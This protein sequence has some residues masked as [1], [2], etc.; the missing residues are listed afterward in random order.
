LYLYILIKLFHTSAYTDPSFTMEFSA[1]M[2]VTGDV[3]VQ[4]KSAFE[5]EANKAVNLEKISN[6]LSGRCGDLTG[7]FTMNTAF[8]KV[9]PDALLV[10]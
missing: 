7:D 8:S 3:A 9:T 2:T 6:R 10:S 5:T 4:C 1:K